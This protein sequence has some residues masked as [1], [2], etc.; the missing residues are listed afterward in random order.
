[1]FFFKRGVKEFFKNCHIFTYTCPNG[2][3][4][5]AI[6]SHDPLED[7]FDPYYMLEVLRKFF[8]DKV[9]VIH[10]LKS[11]KNGLFWPF[12]RVLCINNLY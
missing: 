2:S 11:A 10:P 8:M 5:G 6:D 3:G 12:I 7:V 4:V 9:L 1:M